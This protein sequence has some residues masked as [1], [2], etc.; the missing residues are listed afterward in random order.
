MKT[1]LLVAL[2][3]GANIAFAQN[4]AVVNNKPIP[5]ARED[6]WAK[7]L[8]QQGQ[9]DTP[10]LRKM[11]KEE[12]IRR[13]V[14][15]QEAQK[16]GLPEQ[17]D[18]KFQVDIQRQNTLIQALMRD[19]LKRNP[20]TDEQIQA[21]YD[22]QKAA[23]NQ[24]EYKVRHVLVE[25]EED[26][27]TIIEKLKKGDKFEDLAKVS[28]DPGSAAKGGELDWAGPDAYVKPFSDA[29]VKLEKGKFTEEPVQ[30]Q[31]GWHVIRLDDV[32][33]AQFPPLAQ[34]S[35]QIREN[36]QQQRVQAFVEDLRKKAKVQ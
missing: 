27:R 16:R 22:K 5:K 23:A 35:G 34:V 4:V 18:V 6:A 20:I 29:M 25:K 30:S 19:E 24:K 14:F 15:L 17:P 28:K 21:E 12:L 13:E 3:F 31:F 1:P 2:A 9:Q 32:R 7:Q 26:A 10:E 8:S 33:D 36:L 11:I